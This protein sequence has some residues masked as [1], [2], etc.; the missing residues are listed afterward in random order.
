V[1]F[2]VPGLWVPVVVTSS[3]AVD[4]EESMAHA[5]ELSTKQD[6]LSSRADESMD[7]WI[8]LLGRDPARNLLGGG[9]RMRAQGNYRLGGPVLA[10]GILCA[11][12]GAQTDTSTWDPVVEYKLALKLPCDGDVVPTVA[13]VQRAWKRA[14][15]AIVLTPKDCRTIAFSDAPDQRL[16]KAGIAL[17]QRV[18]RS[19]KTCFDEAGELRPADKWD[20]SAKWTAAKRSDLPTGAGLEPETDWL[21]GAEGRPGAVRGGQDGKGGRRRGAFYDGERYRHPCT[22]GRITPGRSRCQANL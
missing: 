12:A 2:E 21:A 1:N 8:A 14:H 16:R 19:K 22:S 5:V 3:L 6:N 9:R 11:A 4:D 17:R 20:V 7:M 18:G 15:K 10:V 13:V